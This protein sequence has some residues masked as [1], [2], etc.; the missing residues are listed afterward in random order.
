MH[1]NPTTIQIK[2]RKGAYA[3]DL[4]PCPIA[5]PAIP[6]DR[7]AQPPA[8]LNVGLESFCILKAHSP[9]PL[10]E[11]QV[12]ALDFH[13]HASTEAYSEAVSQAGILAPRHAERYRDARP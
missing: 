10:G 3:A 13:L 12:L 7:F 5:I 4:R 6:L 8:T 9:S 11:I 1:H 2:I